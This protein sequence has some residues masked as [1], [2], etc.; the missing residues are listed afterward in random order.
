MAIH[1]RTCWC[2]TMLVRALHSERYAF[3][4]PTHLWP[5]DQTRSGALT[6]GSLSAQAHNHRTTLRS[7]VLPDGPISR[8]GGPGITKNV[9]SR[10]GDSVAPLLFVTQLPTR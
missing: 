1:E 6:N 10:C 3:T 5:F 8:N 9:E 4:S 2:I 7:A